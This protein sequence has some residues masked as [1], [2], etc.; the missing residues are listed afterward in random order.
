MYFSK[1]QKNDDDDELQDEE[2]Q[3]LLE[4]ELLLEEEDEL[5]ELLLLEL[6]E[7]LDEPC[8]LVA[9]VPSGGTNSEGLLVMFSGS[10]GVGR[11]ESLV[12]LSDELLSSP[13]TL[14]LR[15]QVRARMSRV[16][17]PM[18]DAPIMQ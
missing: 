17:L 3:L 9:V 11:I 6:E 10:T 5:E 13:C 15:R 12:M 2:E 8:S 14:T 16:V 7:L 1:P 4:R 18:P